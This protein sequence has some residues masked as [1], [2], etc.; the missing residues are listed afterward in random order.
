[1][2]TPASQKLTLCPGV[3]VDLQGRDGPIR[4]RLRGVE[5]DVRLAGVGRHDCD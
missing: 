2:I 3:F 1:M 4:E 5:R